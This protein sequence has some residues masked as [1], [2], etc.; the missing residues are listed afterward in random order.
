[1]VSEKRLA[2]I[3]LLLLVIV[4][5]ALLAYRYYILQVFGF[6][7]T[8]SDQTVMW[9]AAKNYASGLFHEPLFYGQAYNSMVEALAAVPLLYLGIPVYKALPTITTLLAL[10]PY[11]LLS[12]LTYLKKSR[13]AG[14]LILAFPF[15]LPV[16]YDCL[17]TVS[18][19]FV[20]GIALV[21]LTAILVILKPSSPRTFFLTGT[22]TVLGY[23]VTGNSLLLSVILLGYLLLINYKTRHFYWFTSLGL[24]FGGLLVSLILSFYWTYPNYAIHGYRL[25]ISW[26]YF[27]GAFHHLDKFYQHIIPLFWDHGWFILF[28]P[29]ALAIGFYRLK[30]TKPLLL[31]LGALVLL[32]GPLS[33][34]KIHDGTGSVFFSYSRMFLSVPVILVFL[35][36][37]LDFKRRYWGYILVIIAFFFLGYKALNAPKAIDENLKK[38]S[39][40]SI[41]KVEKLKDPCRSMDTIADRLDVGLVIFHSHWKK[42]LFN[43]GCP[44]LFQGFSKT[45]EP[46]FERRT[47]R[48]KAAED[49]V[50]E[51]ILIVSVK[52][53]YAEDYDFVESLDNHFGFYLVKNNKIPTIEL[54][55]KMDMKVRDFKVDSF[56]RD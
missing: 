36:S 23:L 30:K 4:G 5:V 3:D 11:F 10:L 39:V 48:L 18:R 12:V 55:R 47:W 8:D 15:L 42:N 26:D 34:S 2:R 13:I 19:G 44:S 49:R 51:N 21:S 37:F 41:C 9:L 54:I 22:L 40:I 45:L 32:I 25:E 6:E 35:V 33:V 56:I 16:T 52:R 43:Y 17:T 46:S 27:L 38:N 14:I 53:D 20:T 50:Y 7:Y 24:A 31:A 29:L 1:M 28:F